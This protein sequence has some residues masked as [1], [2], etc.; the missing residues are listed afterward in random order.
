MFF[1]LIW[2]RLTSQTCAIVYKLR[3]HLVEGPAHFP[4][5]LP[6]EVYYQVNNKHLQKLSLMLPVPSFLLGMVIIFQ[7]ELKQIRDI[8]IGPFKSCDTTWKRKSFISFAFSIAGWSIWF[9]PLFVYLPWCREKPNLTHFFPCAVQDHF[10]FYFKIVIVHVHFPLFPEFIIQKFIEAG[11]S[12]C[13]SCISFPMTVACLYLSKC[14]L[15]PGYSRLLYWLCRGRQL[16]P[17]CFQSR[18]FLQKALTLTTC[19]WK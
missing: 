3:E 18:C 10:P 11:A 17:V 1:S 8:P 15:Q 14:G 9:L 2:Y 19:V 7:I 16:L 5:C 13:T 4:G 12:L 6:N